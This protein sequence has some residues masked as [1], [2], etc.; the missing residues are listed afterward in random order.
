MTVSPKKEKNV[1]LQ[2]R[3]KKFF[4]LKL[5]STI[6]KFVLQM[7]V[8]HG[9]YPENTFEALHRNSCHILL[10]S[11]DN[12]YHLFIIYSLFIIK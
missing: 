1:A 11:F 9:C 6:P 7:R 8:I 4:V 5:V 2:A 3:R 10:R 12:K